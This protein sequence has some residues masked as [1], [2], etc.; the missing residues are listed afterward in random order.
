MYLSILEHKKTFVNA[1]HRLYPV[2]KS[3]IDIDTITEETVD[4]GNDM[5]KK[6]N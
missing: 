1:V 3:R 2:D 6:T 4:F 5:D